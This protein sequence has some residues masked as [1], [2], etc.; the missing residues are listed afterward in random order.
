MASPPGKAQTAR[1]GTPVLFLFAAWLAVGAHAAAA[2]GSAAAA[3]SASASA[4]HL[5]TLGHEELVQLV[6]SL[7]PG[8]ATGSPSR[9]GGVRPATGPLPPGNYAQR[10][11]GCTRFG[12]TLW[13]DCLRNATGQMEQS[14]ISLSSCVGGENATITEVGGYLSCQWV[15][16][17]PPRVGNLTDSGSTTVSQMCR[18]VPHVT[19]LAPQFKDPRDPLASFP[20]PQATS[21]ADPGDDDEAAA[22]KC[23]AHCRGYNASA[24]GKSCRGW[25]VTTASDGSRTCQLVSQTDTTSAT[26]S[27]FSGYPVAMDSGSFCEHADD[28]GNNVVEMDRHVPQGIGCGSLHPGK[29]GQAAN[30]SFP[31]QWTDQTGMQRGTVWMFFPCSRNSSTGECIAAEQCNCHRV[32]VGGSDMPGSMAC[33][34]A[35]LGVG[36]ALLEAKVKSKRWTIFIHG[37]EFEW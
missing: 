19:F 25:T 35:A 14:A 15:H 13:C 9:G 37:G 1:A 6:M 7:S 32:K 31:M 20:L 34:G 23:C 2:A 30:L 16:A 24:G 28:N 4:D 5:R 18:M 33:T 8:R 26:L 12:D 11:K 21:G 3:A 17:P 36:S 29:G 27:A 22:A 10:C